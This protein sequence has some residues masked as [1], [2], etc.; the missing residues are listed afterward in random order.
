MQK[1][2]DIKKF[3]D[4]LAVNSDNSDNEIRIAVRNEMKDGQ[5]WL[6]MN[7]T[8]LDEFLIDTTD[9]VVEEPKLDK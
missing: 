2:I 9:V 4:Y 6:I 8:T 3:I 5:V 7:Q 1:V